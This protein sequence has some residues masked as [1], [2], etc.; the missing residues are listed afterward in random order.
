MAAA[1]EFI[2]QDGSITLE[3]LSVLQHRTIRSEKKSHTEFKVSV[4]TNNGKLAFYARYS[5]FRD[6][7]MELE[8]AEL[9]LDDMLS[10]PG[11]LIFGSVER[12][13]LNPDFLH[14][15]Q[16]GLNQ[17]VKALVGNRLKLY[18]QVVE[19]F[20]G[21]EGSSHESDEGPLVSYL[22]EVPS[23]VL[24]GPFGVGGMVQG[25]QESGWE[26]VRHAFEVN[27]SK[28]L[29]CGSQC[30]I[31]H[32]EKKVVDVHGCNAKQP[33]YTDDTMQCVFGCGQVIE[34][35]VMAMLV[36]R[37]LLRYDDKVGKYWPE[38]SKHGKRFVTIA[39]VMR[40]E[41]G[42]PFFTDPKDLSDVKKDRK[43]CFA[44][45]SKD[46]G[47]AESLV[48]NSG[49]YR[50]T[51]PRY[52][53]SVTRGVI[54]GAL[55]KRV[56][57]EGRTLGTFIQEEICVKLGIK[58]VCG[59]P[60]AQQGIYDIAAVQQVNK[61]YGLAFE[62]LPAFVGGG[63]KSVAAEL[64]TRQ[65]FGDGLSPPR[66]R[67]AAAFGEEDPKAPL[68]QNTA[69]GREAEL[70]SVNMHCNARSMAKIT[71]LLANGGE[72][73][74]IRL[75]AAE[76]VTAALEKTR[77]DKEMS[78]ELICG[79]T[80]GGFCNFDGLAGPFAHEDSAAFRGFFGWGGRGGSM[81]LFNPATNVSFAYAMT[82]MGPEEV[83]G[84]RTCSLVAAA[85][86]ALKAAEVSEKYT[87]I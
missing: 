13:N 78:M 6:L 52:Y 34:A 72:F 17:F 12:F 54:I 3:D 62:V 85:N 39:E 86:E 14:D 36:D 37:G 60:E 26:T 71:A 7:Y 82:A 8:E 64:R 24:I 32:G 84:E 58:V 38:F 19:F 75:M 67:I 46:R 68:Q 40:H 57:P 35:I 43:T 1:A 23:A 11:K 47:L 25:T 76:T 22:T 41:G 18:P 53:H 31:Y 70:T 48:S 49:L 20:I 10:F 73:E 74:G 44:A 69:T 2:D 87:D 65:S 15:R 16:R 83:G 56:D 9:I 28:D 27:F 66:I 80:Q 51:R 50:E 79:F 42:V 4:T 45:V 33:Q 61:A 55:L 29:E 30:V 21:P 63:K 77:V 81:L 5:A 59:I